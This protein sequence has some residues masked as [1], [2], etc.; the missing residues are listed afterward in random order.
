MFDFK[1]FIMEQKI[2]KG[3]KIKD[4][5][6]TQYIPVSYDDLGTVIGGELKLVNQKTGEEVFVTN[7]KSLRNSEWWVSYKNRRITD[8]KLA[9]VLKK[10]EKLL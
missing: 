1:T 7:D 6:I 8:K 5:V 9:N 4:F 2:K 3:S 10:L